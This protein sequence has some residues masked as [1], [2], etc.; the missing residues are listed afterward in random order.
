MSSNTVLVVD[1]DTEI[2]YFYQKIFSSDRRSEFDILDVHSIQEGPEIRCQTF[3]DPYAMLGAYQQMLAKNDFCPVCVVDMRMPEMNGLDTARRLRALD[4]NIDI[5]VATAFSDVPI[6][7]IRNRLNER[8]YVVRKPFSQDEFFLLIH[9]LIDAWNIRRSLSESEAIHRLIEDNMT[10]CVTLCDCNGDIQYATKSCMAFFGLDNR[11]LQG[12]NVRSFFSNYDADR[13]L[14]PNMPL[15]TAAVDP[16]VIYD[17]QIH[18]TDGSTAWIGLSAKPVFHGDDQITHLQVTLR[19]VAKRKA[20]ERALLD[21]QLRLRHFLEATQAATWEWLVD[22]GETHFDDRWAGFLGYAISELQPTDYRTWEKLMHPDD[23]IQAK[24]KLTKH[25]AKET[26][27]YDCEFRMKHKNGEW[28]WIH[29]RGKVMSWDSEGMPV[30][31]AG[32][33]TDIHARKTQEASQK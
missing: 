5:V 20:A 3:S 7:E 26:P 10:D 8:I 24:E 12:R 27:F 32:T 23:Y 13:V 28:H 15:C 4:P 16:S 6:Q 19:D 29:A 18:K 11:S 2:L 25:F 22:T 21:E 31:M 33:H 17:M 1:D 9:S 14:G 30:L